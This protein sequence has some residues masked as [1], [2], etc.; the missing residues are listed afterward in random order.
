[1]KGA[2]KSD[3]HCDLQDS[4]NQQK[5]ERILFFRAIPDNMFA[6]MSFVF[7]AGRLP[8]VSRFRVFM[9]QC[10]IRCIDTSVWVVLDMRNVEHILQE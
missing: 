9:F 6:S 4:M 1:M 7:S 5:I 8:Q 10:S 2:A 3:K